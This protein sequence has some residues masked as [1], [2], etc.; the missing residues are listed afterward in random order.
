MKLRHLVSDKK[1][2]LLMISGIVVLLII[3]Y[4]LGL[5][6]GPEIRPLYG[7]DIGSRP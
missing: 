5:H 7:V 6:S 4:Y 1:F 3:I 2:I